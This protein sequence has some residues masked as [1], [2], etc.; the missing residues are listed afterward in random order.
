MKLLIKHYG[1]VLNG[2]KIYYNQPLYNQQLIQLE[3]K[4]FCEIIEERARKITV[5]QH[6]YYRGGIL[7]ACFESEMFNGFD[8]PDDI[9]TYYFSPKFLSY[10]KVINL[11]NGNKKE[12]IQYQSMADLTSK[13]TSNFIERVLA[14]CAE[15][16]IIILSPDEYYNKFYK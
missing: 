4:E 14:D 11:P 12:I 9:H 3:G 15:N 2:K 6:N 7:P 1:K 13:E 16:Q 5:P 8:K 10:T